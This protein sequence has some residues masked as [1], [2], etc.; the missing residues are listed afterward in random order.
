MEIDII[1]GKANVLVGDEELARRREGFVPFQ[2]D[3][4]KGSCLERYANQVTSAM[5]GA[6]FK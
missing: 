5:N 4:P 2:K 1:N 3:I 6:V